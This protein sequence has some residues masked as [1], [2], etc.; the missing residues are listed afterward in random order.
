MIDLFKKNNTI[1]QRKNHMIFRITFLLPLLI[2]TPKIA[3]SYEMDKTQWGEIPAVITNK[4]DDI[5]SGAA[6]INHIKNICPKSEDKYSSSEIKMLMLKK[7]S[8]NSP[9]IYKTISYNYALDSYK[10]KNK[11]FT[12]IYKN[13][14]CDEINGLYLIADANDFNL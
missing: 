12:E 6:A 4:I 3:L 10:V 13:K 1:S 14:K 2:F 11:V 9:E 5:T 8:K 7:V